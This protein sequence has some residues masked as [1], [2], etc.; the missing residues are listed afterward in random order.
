MYVELLEAINSCRNCK[1]C[2][3]FYIRNSTFTAHAAGCIMCSVQRKKRR[4][5]RNT[6]LHIL[7][8]NASR[9]KTVR[10]NK[11]NNELEYL[12]MPDN[13]FH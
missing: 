8:E 6:I 1:L 11:K 13:T 2:N 10:K 12:E 3:G 7:Q 4:V 9:L 5:Y